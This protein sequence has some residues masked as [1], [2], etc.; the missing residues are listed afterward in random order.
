MGE[1]E[2]STTSG[3]ERTAGA[4]LTFRGEGDRGCPNCGEV[5]LAFDPGTGRARCRACGEAN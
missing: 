1:T 2:R 3:V 4:S 5:A